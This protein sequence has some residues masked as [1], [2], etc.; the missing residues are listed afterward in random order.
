MYSIL[1]C[2]WPEYFNRH[3][4]FFIFI[5]LFTNMSKHTLTHANTHTQTHTHHKQPYTR[6]QTHSI[7]LSLKGSQTAYAL[8]KSK[9]VVSLS[10]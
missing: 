1:L 9:T 4:L 2:P 6:T 3:T 10:L 7:F 5:S 8:I